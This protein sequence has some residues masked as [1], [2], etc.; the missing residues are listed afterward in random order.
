M[1]SILIGATRHMDVLYE[2]LYNQFKQ[3]E[4]QGLQLKIEKNLAGKFTFLA[5]CFNNEKKKHFK[6]HFRNN[7][8]NVICELI[9]NHWEKLILENI[10]SDAYYYFNLDERKVILANAIKQLGEEKIEGYVKQYAGKTQGIRTDRKSKIL[11]ELNEYLDTSNYIVIDGF[12]RFRL[13]EY[14]SE[15]YEA[16]EQA[17][18]NFLMERE[19][20]EFIQLLKYFVDIQDPAINCINVTLTSDGMF[21]LYDEKGNII[22]NDYLKGY[23]IELIASEI[24]YE[25]FLISSLVTIA[26]NKIVFHFQPDKKHKN[27]LETIEKVFTDRVAYCEGCTLCKKVNQ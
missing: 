9:L 13:K 17:V 5:C 1:E 7:I 18:D 24:N 27:T 26:P 12:I 6:N 19:Y 23:I 20:E 25:D 2:K 3:L 4:N 8:S 16:A 22:D 21:T 14:I 15:L 10:I 11:K